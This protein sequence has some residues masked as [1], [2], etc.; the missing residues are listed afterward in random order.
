MYKTEIAKENWRNKYKYKDEIPIGTQERIA[1]SLASVEKNP[2]YWYP[3]FL[4]TLVKFNNN[5]AVG[6]K[7]TVG[8]RIAANI[9][10]DYKNAS[11]FNCYIS[12]EVT[13]ATVQYKRQIPNTNEFIDIKYQTPD[14]GDDMYNIILTVLEQAKTLSS[15]GGWG[16]NASFLRP[17]GTVVSGIGVKHPGVCKF[18]EIFDKVSEVIVAGV[19]DG[20]IAPLKNYL[21]QDEIN[22]IGYKYT[23][24]IK[25][26]ARKGAMMVNLNCFSKDT[27]ILTNVGWINITDIIFNTDETIYAICDDGNEYKIK[28]PI[29]KEPEQIY[30]VETED[31]STI[32]VTGDHQ[33]EVL[34]IDTQE[35]YLK[36]IKDIDSEKEDIKIIEIMEQKKKIKVSFQKLKSITPLKVDT[37]YDFEVENKHRIIARH[38]NS[39]SNKGFYTSNCN[40]PDIE[41]FITAKQTSKRLTKFNMSVLITDEFMNAVINNEMFDLKFNGKVYKRVLAT[42]LYELIM[43]STYNR[44]EPGV[45]FYDNMQKNN[46]ISYIGD[47]SSVNPCVAKGTLVS[48]INGLIPVEEIKIGDR[49]ETTNGFNEVKEIE[50]HENYPVYKVEFSDGSSIR[51]TEGH[52]FHSMDNDSRKKW[53]DNIPLKDLKI[54]NFI[55]K[56]SSTFI[57]SK[58]QIKSITPDGYDTVYDLYEPTTDTWIANGLVNRGC[59][60]IP[61]NTKITTVCLLGSINVT[62]YV[63]TNRTFDFESYKKDI[64]VFARMLDNVNDLQKNDLPAY[65]YVIKNVRQFGM[66]LNGFGS[67]LYMLGIR[68][69]SKESIAFA[70]KLNKIKLNECLRTTALLAKEKGTAPL[71]DKKKFYKTHYWTTFLENKLDNDVKQLVEKYGVRNL[72]T[73]TQPPLG[74]SSVICDNISNGL[75]PVFM[76]EYERKYIAPKWPEGMNI[77][78][79]KTLLKEEKEADV[80]VWKGMFNGVKYYYEPHNRGLCIVE[81]IYDYGYNWVKENFPD[82]IK[83]KKEYL[84]TSNDL[85]V[86]EHV[87]IQKMFQSYVDQSIS[88]TANVPN[89][90]PYKNFKDLYMD[91]WKSGL[92]GFTTYR[93]GTMESVISTVEEQKETKQHEV[94]KNVKLPNVFINGDCKVIKKE[95]MKFYIHFSYLPEDKNL[96]FPI[97]MWIQTNHK[98]KGEIPYINKALKKLEQLLIDFDIDKK[99][100]D[101]Q[102]EKIKDDIQNVKIAKMIS[103]CLRHNVPIASIVTSLENIEGDN[104]STLLF[105][106]RKFLSS[107]IKDG[108]EIKGKKCSVCGTGKLI[109]ESGCS[110]CL[111]CGASNCG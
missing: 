34:N 89:K 15:E 52:I 22:T 31:G 17:R 44:N 33:F 101:K 3:I 25:E 57:E 64:S 58:I 102:L 38:T 50:V 106:I 56:Q 23:S 41:E 68:Y 24:T 2:D 45:L 9:G 108:E 69:G 70:E 75:E 46:P 5:E 11:L 104:V 49:I 66:G 90:Y 105:A 32:E 54:G 53:N 47:V 6:L 74:N 37:T 98:F 10:T 19:E 16:F 28:N 1:K 27:E 42:E 107:H 43:K 8:G 97:A 12:G 100:I 111:D 83:N 20:Y 76:Y 67:L 72:K 39:I 86:S 84:V 95:D 63:T 30:L 87:E 48:T 77:N 88:K 71:F 80:I 4:N 26:M 61:G 14:T 109:F 36:P 51:V 13:N 7:S 91:A 73:T 110:K 18:L 79:V 99:Q 92:N 103:M 93:E 85:E 81:K 29:I 78:N 96:V 59:G 40:H 65:L 62:Q 55:R 21:T 35:I 82:D 94:I 60:E